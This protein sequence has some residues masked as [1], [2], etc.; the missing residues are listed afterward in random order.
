MISHKKCWLQ[1]IDLFRVLAGPSETRP[2]AWI[3]QVGKKFDKKHIFA[4]F[5]K[6]K[7]K[8]FEFSNDQT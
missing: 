4:N 3:I 6:N 7:F 2:G 5:T 8:N 1:K